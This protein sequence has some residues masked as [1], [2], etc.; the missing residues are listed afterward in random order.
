MR[1]SL[2]SLDRA[3]S[4]NADDL[5]REEA[6]LSTVDALIAL[7]QRQRGYFIIDSVGLSETLQAKIG[8]RISKANNARIVSAGPS[9]Y[10]VATVYFV[11]SGASAL[12]S[13]VRPGEELAVLAEAGIG[14]PPDLYAAH[15]LAGG[16]SAIFYGTTTGDKLPAFNSAVKGVIEPK[17]AQIN[18]YVRLF[19]VHPQ[20]FRDSAEFYQAA[21]LSIPSISR[22]LEL[23][24]KTVLK[25]V[26]DYREAMLAQASVFRS[27]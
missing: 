11:S 10:A 19:S 23:R 14:A 13:G 24:L 4:E 12:P 5:R 3:L 1:Y 2:S 25:L 6:I 8:E 22:L 16:Y 20:T 18:A 27:A 7:A 21:T 17:L 9:G 26:S 15:T